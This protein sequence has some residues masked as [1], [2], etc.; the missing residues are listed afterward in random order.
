M[1]QSVIFIFLL[2]LCFIKITLC[3]K[4]FFKG[5]SMHVLNSV[6]AKAHTDGYLIRSI[7]MRPLHLR[8][9]FSRIKTE[10]SLIVL[11]IPR[12]TANLLLFLFYV[13]ITR[14]VKY[15]LTWPIVTNC[16][17]CFLR[18]FNIVHL[19]F[20]LICRRA[21]TLILRSLSC[22]SRLL[23]KLAHQFCGCTIQQSCLRLTC[24]SRT[25]NYNPLL[26]IFIIDPLFLNINKY[27]EIHF[28]ESRY[29]S[30]TR[31]YSMIFS[32]PQFNSKI[33]I[34]V[35]ELFIICV[36]TKYLYR[37]SHL[38]NIFRYHVCSWERVF[39]YFFMYVLI[40]ISLSP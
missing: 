34:I 26:E 18:Y 8:F 35:L 25:C 12:L 20:N 37:M 33:A 23:I 2:I 30:I 17:Y 11:H 28:T 14:I 36:I 40:E 19:S 9:F 24:G 4:Y 6:D 15:A 10:H 38:L 22:S 39:L 7:H 3:N 32:S 21:A 16:Y 5:I 31:L 1:F 27:Y 29:K 13:I